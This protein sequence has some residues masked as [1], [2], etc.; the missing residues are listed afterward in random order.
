MLACLHFEGKYT[1]NTL[2]GFHLSKKCWFLHDMAI[3]LYYPSYFFMYR[4]ILYKSN[5]FFTKQIRVYTFI[6]PIPKLTTKKHQQSI[7]TP[8]RP[9]GSNLVGWE[10]WFFIKFILSHHTTRASI[11]IFCKHFCNFLINYMIKII[12]ILSNILKR[13]KNR[14][15]YW[16]KGFCISTLFLHLTYFLYKIEFLILNSVFWNQNIKY[17]SVRKMS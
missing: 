7:K 13:N 5:Y 2:L 3:I 1:Q 10:F 15:L 9:F 11:S 14:R 4:I 8:N 6:N 17:T 16:S 12:Y